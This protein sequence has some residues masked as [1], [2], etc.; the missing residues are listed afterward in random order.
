[1]GARMGISNIPSYN[2]ALKTYVITQYRVLRTIA[3][4]TFC[5][6]SLGV[7]LRP[8]VSETFCPSLLGAYRSDGLAEWV[9]Q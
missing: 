1:M 3:S 6:S 8:I 2:Y 9:W 5:P 7:V 4:D